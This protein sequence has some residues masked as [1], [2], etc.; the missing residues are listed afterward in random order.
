MRRHDEMC[1]RA[2]NEREHRGD[3][4]TQKKTRSRHNTATIM[5]TPFS[6]APTTTTIG[7]RLD[8]VLSALDSLSSTQLYALIVGLT[9]IVCWGVLAMSHQPEIPELVS[10]T[11]AAVGSSSSS[12]PRKRREGPEPR[13]HFI[14]WANIVA[15]IIFAWSVADF[16]LN[17][18]TYWND[19]SDSN[20]LFK[21]LLGWSSLLCYF[22]GFFGVSFVHDHLADM[23]TTT[24]ARSAVPPAVT[25]NTR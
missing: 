25:A 9:V 12:T 24:T 18:T 2:T 17:A 10:T 22:F 4:H 19:S 3:T 13:W 11:A 14:R 20:V 23:E 21:F 8:K 16:S 1:L 6:S 7:M 5:T 15:V